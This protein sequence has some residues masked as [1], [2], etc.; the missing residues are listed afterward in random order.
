MICNITLTT[1]TRT[2]EYICSHKDQYGDS[3]FSYRNLNFNEYAD[4]KINKEE[5]NSILKKSENI[6]ENIN[7]YRYNIITI[8]LN[9]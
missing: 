9:K 6:V 3:S 1:G 8:I 2:Y 5:C 7:N 4:G